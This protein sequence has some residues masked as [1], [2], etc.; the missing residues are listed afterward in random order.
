MS[1]R[2]IVFVPRL[3]FRKLQ[4]RRVAF[5]GYYLCVHFFILQNSL[6]E[7]TL[8]EL[9]LSEL[10]NKLLGRHHTG[11]KGVVGGIYIPTEC[12]GQSFLGREVLAQFSSRV[13][14]QNNV[15]SVLTGCGGEVIQ[16]P[17]S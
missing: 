5:G 2:G 9:F 7:L 8:S 13:G 10:H 14:L 1:T 15:H 16:V 12:Q 11:S 3:H 17:N 4:Q 6:S